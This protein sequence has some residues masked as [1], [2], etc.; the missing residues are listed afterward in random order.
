MAEKAKQGDFVYIEFLGRVAGTGE[1]FDTT[2][3][4][5]ARENNIFDK[6]RSYGPQ[7]VILG[8]GQLL[9]GLEKQIYALAA[10]EEKEFSLEAKEAFGQRNTEL[11]RVIGM[12]EFA[13]QKVNP[14]AGMIVSLDGRLARVMSVN[15]GRVMIDLNHPL[16]G[17]KVSYKLKLDRILGS[18]EEKAGA[19]LKASGLEG[20]AEIKEKRLLVRGK[21]RE[22]KEHE[23]RLLNLR[24]NVRR[25]LPEIEKVEWEEEKEGK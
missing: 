18:L 19:L 7:L 16:A 10:G 13:R 21:E 8:K 24:Q 17:E 23:L 20:E 2:D 3:E 25:Y 14:N 5:T 9:P 11:I 15:S 4:K 12:A 22:K 1:I 6:E